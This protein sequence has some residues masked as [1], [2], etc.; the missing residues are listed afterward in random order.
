MQMTKAHKSSGAVKLA[1]AGTVLGAALQLMSLDAAAE[2]WGD[3]AIGWR[4]GTKFAEPYGTNDI[5]KNIFNLT[6]AGGYKYGT[7]FFNVDLLLSDDKD[8]AHAKSNEGAQEAY[9]VYRNTVDF[10]KIAGSDLK[11]G[12]I[13]GFGATFGF[14]WNT[15]TD[16][17][18][19]SKKRML[20]LGPTLMF[21]VPGFLDV[22]LLALRE[23]NA[24]CNTY[25][26]TCEDRYTYDTHAAL[27][28]AWGIA[29]GSLPLSF[30]GFALFIDS[31]GDDEFGAKTKAET[32]IDMQVMLDVGSVVGGAPKTFKL[33]VE[34]QYWKNKFGNDHGGPAGD[35]AFAKTPMLRAEYHF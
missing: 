31:K 17:G 7:N 20:V 19:N 14:D 8:P 5:H 23:S 13:R 12:I 3:T 26:D 6:H 4:Y 29:I 9:V 18:Y 32:N 25:S 10:G 11:V 27:S 35:G 2:V 30:E 33:G 21:D 24:P 1:V 34:Y 16:A 15:K 22:S 28:A